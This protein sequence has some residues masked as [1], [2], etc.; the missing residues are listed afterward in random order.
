MSSINCLSSL[1]LCTNYICVY[2]YV[3]NE[4]AYIFNTYSTPRLT[5]MTGSQAPY[6]QTAR[7]YNMCADCRYCRWIKRTKFR[8]SFDFSAFPRRR[9]ILY[10]NSRFDR[11]KTY[12]WSLL[13]QWNCPSRVLTM[14]SEHILTACVK[15]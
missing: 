3:S 1:F 13:H 15:H 4:N 14:K 5:R 11:E 2:M 6:R 7:E 12:N 9:A 10:L 8:K